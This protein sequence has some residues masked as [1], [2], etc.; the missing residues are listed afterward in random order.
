[1]DLKYQVNTFEQGKEFQKFF[2]G[3]ESTPQSYFVWARTNMREWILVEREFAEEQ[4]A[5]IIPAFLGTEL[6]VLLP[7]LVYFPPLCPEKNS[8]E[9]AGR[10][11]ASKCYG[12][13]AE[14]LF[15]YF[16]DSDWTKP[17]IVNQSDTPTWSK[18]DLLIRLIKEEKLIQAEDLSF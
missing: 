6:D 2:K 5:Q 15:G 1:M 10:L 7:S 12:E 4:H 17:L 16:Q 14:W 3:L 8:A 11:Q 18:S 13:K 9:R